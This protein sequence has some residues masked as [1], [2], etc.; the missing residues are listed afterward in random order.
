MSNDTISPYTK[1]KYWLL[2]KNKD[3]DFPE[4]LENI[5]SPIIALGMFSKIPK[6]KSFIL[7]DEFN[8]FNSFGKIH[9]NLDFYKFLKSIVLDNNLNFN[10][11]S[12]CRIGKIK[13]P[14]EKEYLI[15]LYPYLKKYE[16]NFLYKQIIENDDYKSILSVV[17][18]IKIKKYKVKKQKKKKGK[19]NE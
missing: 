12:F 3:T 14:E 1:F 11:F 2:D 18:N 19:K 9:D 17:D 6:I 15:K 4:E 16:I 13:Q 7:N 5:I 8:N 10:D